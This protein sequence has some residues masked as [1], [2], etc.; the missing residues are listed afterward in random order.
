VDV[1]M[2]PKYRDQITENAQMVGEILCAKV[3]LK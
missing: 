1:G 3:M 2:F